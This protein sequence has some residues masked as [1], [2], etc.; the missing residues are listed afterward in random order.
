MSP[1][2][3][4]F[5]NDLNKI[6]L[7]SLS[8]REQN[9]LIEI[10]LRLKDQSDSLIHFTSSELCEM[11]P[12]RNYSSTEITGIIKGLEK[13]FFS[14]HFEQLIEH[15]NGSTTHRFINLFRVFEYK[16]TP[17]NTIE[18]LDLQV[19]P[20]MTFILNNLTEKFTRFELADF[21]SLQSKYSKTLFRL[22]K[23][24]RTQG[25]AQFEWE[26]FRELMG[27]PESYQNRNIDQRILKPAVE[28]LSR[29][30]GNDLF[31]EYH[32]STP[33]FKNLEY[34]KIKVKGR[35]RGGKVGA[36]KFTF[37]KEKVPVS[38]E[39]NLARIYEEKNKREWDKKIS[40]LRDK[41]KK[42]NTLV[43]IDAGIKKKLLSYEID[44]AELTDIESY[45]KMIFE[46]DKDLFNTWLSIRKK[47]DD[48]QISYFDSQC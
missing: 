28:E 8:S 37:T 6:P 10:F 22:L 47:I 7:G 1:K 31:V 29:T 13:N 3:V 40:E 24:F 19:D 4:Q 23:Q 44:L 41:A 26:S 32:D 43:S 42:L 36:I 30:K 27:I 9:L 11:G 48:I 12:F 25:W 45:A 21:L 14:L 35:G 2:I 16:I 39:K 33:T 20:E 5:R 18:Y 34:T 17:E 38:Y 46:N 15:Q